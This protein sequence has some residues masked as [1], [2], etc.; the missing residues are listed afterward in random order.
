MWP[1][2]PGA[3]HRVKA[4]VLVVA[5]GTLGTC[6][7]AHHGASPVRAYPCVL[8]RPNELGPDF[9][10]RQHVEAFAGGRTGSFDGVLQ[11]R[12]NELVIVGLGPAGVRAF[13]LKQTSDDLSFERSLDVDLPFPPRNI[14]VD[15]HRAFFKRLTPPAS[16]AGTVRAKLDDE[17]VEEDW[18]DGHLV[19]R[20]FA[21]RDPS[22]QGIVRVTFASGCKAARCAPESV[23]LVNEWFSYSLYITN[24]EWVWL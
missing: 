18:R 20:R 14:L 11:K 12:G 7:C 1:F 5:V 10:T 22:L 24:T 6:A 9:S 15:V 2:C 19:E 17:D 8:H 23:R 4:G 21:R 13:V 3:N 16:G